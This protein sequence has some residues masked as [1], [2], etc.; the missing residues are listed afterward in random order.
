MIEKSAMA[1]MSDGFIALPGGIGTLEELF[2][3]WTWEQ[4]GQHAKP[5]AL[6][7][8]HGLYDGLTSFLDHIVDE[9]FLKPQ[10]REML[11]VERDVDKLLSA[12]LSYHPPKVTKWRKREET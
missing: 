12:V 10:H 5:C 9:A 6:L 11:I 1:E 3:V 4:L 7:N 8:I 2:E